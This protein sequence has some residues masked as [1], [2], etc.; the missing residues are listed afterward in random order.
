MVKKFLKMGVVLAVILL[1][2]SP[3]SRLFCQDDLHRVYA[4][5][6]CRIVTQSGPP[7]ERGT[8]VIRDGLIKSVG[9]EVPVPADAEVIDGSKL[10]VYPGLTDALGKS[11][12]KL[13]ERKFDPTKIYTGDY[14]D[15]DRGI[16]PEFKALTYFEISRSGLEKYHKAGITAAMVIPER[17]IFTGQ[18]SVFCLSGT[19]KNKTVILKDTCLGVGF[20]VGGFTLYPSSLMGVVALL[21]QQFSDASYFDRHRARWLEEMNG[22]V[23]PGYNARYE[24]LSDFA[25]GRKPVIFLCRNRYDIRRALDLSAELNLDFFICDLGSEA[26]RMIPELKKAKARLF[27]PLDFKVP[28]SSLYAQKGSEARKKAEQELY[29]KNPALLAEAGIPF[30]FTSLGTDDPQSFGEGV[31][32]AI[33]NGLPREKALGALTSG[34]ALFLGLEEALGTVEPGKIANLALVEGEILTEEAKVRY[35]FADGIKFEI[36]EAEA[37][38]GEKPTV[39]VSGK[40]EIDIPEAGLKLT[41][42]FLQEEAALSGKLTTPFGV[43]DFSGGSVSLN[44]VYFEINLSVGGQDIDLYFSAV[45]E[46]D[47]MTGTV[48]QGTEGSTEFTAKRIPGMGATR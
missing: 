43:F 21:R 46:G 26:F 13:P 41:I 4:V 40:W 45:V 23:R 38:E 27:V 22:L 12:L 17:G 5:K 1:L 39:N 9:Q 15:E 2:A 3:F 14:T 25:A 29:M 6:N 48:V 34:A 33:E 24:V 36:K 11:L 8:V 35:V 47:K 10:T 30:T 7:I 28:S 18:A 19:G 20:S 31:R 37:R 42:D 32:K 44:Q 16:T